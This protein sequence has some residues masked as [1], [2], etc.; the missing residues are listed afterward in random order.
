MKFPQHL[1]KNVRRHRRCIADPQNLYSSFT[2]YALYSQFRTSEDFAGL[3]VKSLA[4]F[5]QRNGI[6]STNEKLHPELFLQVFNLPAERRLRE[7]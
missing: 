5:R 6:L 4:C 1:R 3:L 2:S 7:I